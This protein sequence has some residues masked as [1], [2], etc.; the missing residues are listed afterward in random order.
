MSYYWADDVLV[1]RDEANPIDLS[2]RKAIDE[3]LGEFFGDF[4]N[5]NWALRCL[6]EHLKIAE[7]PHPETIITNINTLYKKMRKEFSYDFCIEWMVEF[8]STH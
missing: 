6:A 5:L 1:Y 3:F 7:E 4:E 8:V 2:P